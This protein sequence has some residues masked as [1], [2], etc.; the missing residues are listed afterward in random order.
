MIQMRFDLLTLHPSML[1]GPLN[2]SILGRA[3]AAGIVEIGVHNIRDYSENKHKTVDD[4]PYGG[5]AG[6]VMR[7]DIVARAI[8]SV[9]TPD[10]LVLLTSPGGVPFVQARAEHLAQVPHLIIVC[11][12]YEGIDAR[13]ES[14]VDG[15]LSIGDFVLTGGEIAAAAVVDAVARLVPGVLG[16]ADS[17][18]DESF[19]SG[20]LEYPH[21]TRPREWRGAVVPDVL[22]SGH[23]ENISIWRQEQAVLRTQKLRPDLW[24]AYS[25]AGEAEE[26]PPDR[27]SDIDDS[28]G[29]E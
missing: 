23:H 26:M 7:V 27:R 28:P 11:G 20:L 13:I 12:H 4:A 17:A 14:L 19:A 1:E 16:N 22:L 29:K 8:A 18:K 5:G 24:E 2:T 6:M 21:Y 10:S 3:Q 9:R 25:S 15:L